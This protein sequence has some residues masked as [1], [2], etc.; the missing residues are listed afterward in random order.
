[1]TESIEV[2]GQYQTQSGHALPRSPLEEAIA[3]MEGAAT[4]FSLDAIS[5][6]RTRASYAANIKRVSTQV[7]ADV[8]AGKITS[9][10]GTEFC[11]EMRNK[12]MAEHRKITSAVG[13]AKA[14]Q[15]KKTPPTLPQLFEKYA[16]D[17]FGKSYEALTAEQKKQIHYKVIESSGRDNAKF[18]KGTQRLRIMGKVGILV[19][20]TFATYEVLNAENKKKEAARQGVIIGGGAAG[21]FLA[22][23]GVSLICGP[24][25]PACAIAVVLAGSA[26][27]G[28][29]G[30]MAADAMDEELEEFSKWEV[31]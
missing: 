6:A 19:T 1:M 17:E 16:T 22:G 30:S 26:I 2:K 5:D 7:R 29:A 12:I 18:T 13:L 11:Y 21:G 3:G 14:E 28:I 25:A 9:Q 15:Y 24:G 20:A 8:T 27:G 31:F 4:R 23:L 10:A